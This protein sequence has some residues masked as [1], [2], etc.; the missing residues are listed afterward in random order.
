MDEPGEHADDG[1]GDDQLQD[2]GQ[3]EEDTGDGHAGDGGDN[4]E[5][6]A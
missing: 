3:D 5:D 2:A 4:D 1:D 6:F